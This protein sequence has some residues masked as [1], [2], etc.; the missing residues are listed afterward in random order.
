MIV[1]V[2][3]IDSNLKSFI[4]KFIYFLLLV[5]FFYKIFIKYIV[6]YGILGVGLEEEIFY[7][8]KS[9]GLSW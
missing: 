4:Y 2:R 5:N 3:V 1:R 7:S 9:W 8:V 6:E